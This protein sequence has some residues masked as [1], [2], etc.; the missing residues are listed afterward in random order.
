MPDSPTQFF[1]QE[2]ATRVGPLALVT[3]DNGEDWQKPNV[4]G[5]VALESLGELVPR[6]Q[7]GSWSGLVLTGKP[8]VFAVGADLTEF[9]AMSTPELAR[10][11]A[12][13]GH[14]AFGAIRDLPFP[15][16]AAINGA[17]LGGGLE[18]A[19]HCDFR[20][21]ARSVRH[22][23]FPEV[24]L[25]IIPGVGRHPART[26]VVGA[27]AAV[28]LIVANPLKQNRLL[29]AA[30][31]A[32][33]GLADELLDDVEFL[34]DSIEWLVRAIE[35]G[36]A[37]RAVAD[38]SD[39]AEV[40][41]KARYAVDDAVHGVA[42]APYR[43]LELIAGSAGWTIEE[44]YAAEE[45]ALG[46]LL[47]GP[48]AQAAV[49]AFDLV[50]RQI[51]KGVGIPDAKPRRIQKVGVV[52]A[53]LMATQLAT[54]FLRRLEVPLVITDVDA[55]RVEEAV[56]A[57]RADLEKQASR[58]RLSEG[59]ARFLGSIV[60]GVADT[61]AFAGCDLVIEAVFEEIAVKQ[62][63][64]GALEERRLGGVP[65]R[66]EHVVTARRRDGGRPRSTRSASWGCT[67]STRSRCSR[68]SSSCAR[69]PRTT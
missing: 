68:S 14:D 61:S 3:M 25:G 9:P 11:A 28:E 58:G 7:D 2:V 56:A 37:P 34:D 60:N 44:G 29:H 52:G 54:L 48:Q 16:L 67:S 40:C 38:L 22:I 5:R 50:E 4:F 31:A 66:H 10:A 17:A 23:G 33:L 59:K 24:F 20:T 62:E 18:I 69:R 39:A 49:Y 46:D 19:L 42:L 15:T 26:R 43:A 55:A 35:E 57:I 51:K 45:E 36:R 21:L 53:G 6:L 47:P 30:Q 1:L 13:A 64:F 65:A 27:A 32:E 41:A 63:V 8:F 12:K